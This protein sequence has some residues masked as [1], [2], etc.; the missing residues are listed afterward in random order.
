MLDA[1]TSDAECKR[2]LAS[3]ENPTRTRHGFKIY[4]IPGDITSDWIKLHGQ[5]EAGP[6]RFILD[7]L[8]RD[9]AFLDIGANIGYFS[10][11]AAVKGESRVV[12]FEPQREVAD[13]LAR[14]IEMNKLESLVRVE[15]IALSNA[16]AMMRMTRCPGNT[17]HSQLTSADGEGVLDYAVRVVVLDEWMRENPIGSVSVCK[18]DAE[19]AD[20]DI[21]RGMSG[22]LDRDG[23]AIVVEVIDEFLAPFGESGPGILELLKDHGY[24]DV[25]ARYTCHLDCNRYFVKG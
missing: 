3:L 18:I 24:S 21:L 14:S 5:H 20:L 7:H 17:G 9:T 13:L 19:G 15:P 8:K 23:P 2:W 6:E 12:S 16:P 4:T 25:S 1:L 10:L 11:L 22:L